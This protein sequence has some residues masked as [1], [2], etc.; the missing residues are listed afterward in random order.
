MR[1]FK[2]LSIDGGGI[3]GLY[4]AWILAH[5]ERQLRKEHGD[6]TR[7]VDFVDLACGT[8]TGGLI[9]LGI[10]RRIPMERICDFYEQKGPGIFKRSVGLFALLRQTLLGG[11]YSDKALRKA[12]HELLQDHTIE[13]SH[14]LL[15]IPTYDFTHGTYGVFKYDHSEGGLSRHNSL[16]MVD[17]ALATSAAPTFFPLAEIEKENGTQYVDGGVWANNPSLVGFTEAIWHFVG[18]DKPYDRI[19]FLSVASLNFS[20]GQAPGLKR[21]R[22]FI[23]WAADLFD[24]SLI[25]Q[26]E[27]TDVFLG[28]MQR[29]QLVPIIYT[30]I[31]SASISREQSRYVKL[32]LATSRSFNLMRQFGSDAYHRYRTHPAVEDFF[33]RKKSYHISDV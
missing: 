22:G 12:L 20:A 28:L 26:C 33:S 13:D 25:A 30:R 23:R 9:A 17:V 7:I 10:S 1:D 19:N 29:L 27:F 31:P 2:V 14:C 18:P 15:C 11:K 5:F 3:K 24:L 32:D 8:S 6:D 4:S 21:S 16:P